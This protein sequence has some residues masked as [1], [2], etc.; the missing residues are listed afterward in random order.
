MYEALCSLLPVQILNLE[1]KFILHQ[2]YL[3]LDKNNVSEPS[4]VPSS[5]YETVQLDDYALYI[6]ITTVEDV[7]SVSEVMLVV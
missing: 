5:G 3:K 4:Q 2:S 7:D 1:L 6:H